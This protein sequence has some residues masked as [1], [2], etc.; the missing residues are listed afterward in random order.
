[1]DRATIAATIA[2]LITSFNKKGV[3]VTDASTFA[4][5][6]EFELRCHG[7]APRSRTLEL[8]GTEGCLRVDVEAL[9]RE[10]DVQPSASLTV[11]RQA[12][13]P[14]ESVCRPLPPDPRDALW[15]GRHIWERVLTYTFKIADGQ[16]DLTLVRWVRRR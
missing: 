6:L 11:L 2:S 9:S 13:R 5:D 10:D 4:G 15:N 14:T 7:L 3:P 12:L 8:H 1:M 16:G